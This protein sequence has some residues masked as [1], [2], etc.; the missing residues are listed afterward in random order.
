MG[1]TWYYRTYVK[2]SIL[3]VEYSFD[4]TDEYETIFTSTNHRSTGEREFGRYKRNYE[5]KFSL[6]KYLY[7]VLPNDEFRRFVNDSFGEDLYFD[8]KYESGHVRKCLLRM[9]KI[10]HYES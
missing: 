3:Y 6:L 7:R 8:I 9:I 5:N 2:D 1:F 10:V 4:C